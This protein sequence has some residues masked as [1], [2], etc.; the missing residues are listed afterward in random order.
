MNE[1]MIG[2]AARMICESR[3]TL[4]LT[5]AGI[6]VDSGIPD[7][8]SP[9]GLWDRY[10]PAEYGTIWAFHANPV[11]VWHMIREMSEMVNR[12]K[13]NPAHLG[14]AQLQHLGLLHTIITQNIDSLHQ[15][16]GASR[17]IEYHGSSRTL[18]CLAC[19]R[20]FKAEETAGEVPPRCACTEILKPDVVFFGELIPVE[21]LRE[22]QHL[23]SSCD[24]LVVVGTSAQVAPANTLPETAKLG[25]ARI[26]E[27][28]VQPTVLTSSFTDIFLQGKAGAMVARL[29][30]EVQGLIARR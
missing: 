3:L 17:V 20:R 9:G 28:N 25:G 4:A 7:F 27:I 22:S 21:A 29:V 24:T 10:D 26:I 30:E 5:G 14:L 12:A 1:E 8:R 11:K 15:R 13:P 2:K 16:A 23:A 6:S 18:S 19:G